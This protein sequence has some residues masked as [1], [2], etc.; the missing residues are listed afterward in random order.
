MIVRLAIVALCSAL[1]SAQSV[2]RDARELALTKS[3]DA[4]TTTFHLR[5]NY[6]A[7]ATAW[8]VEC[9]VETNHGQAVAS[10]WYWSDQEIGFEGKPL[11]PG[12]EIEFRIPSIPPNLMKAGPTPAKCENF[13]VVA[14]VF[15][16]GTVSGD[17]KWINAIVG[18]RQR[19]YQDITRATGLLTSAVSSN[20]DR[21]TLVKQLSDWAETESP[22]RARRPSPN[23]A[24]IFGGRNQDLPAGRKPDVDRFPPGRMGAVPCVTIWLL[25]EK[26]SGLTEAIG[27]LSEWRDRLGQLA[28]VT[29]PAQPAPAFALGNLRGRMPNDSEWVGKPAPDFTLKAVDGHELALKDLRGKTVFVD[30]WATWCVPCRE[31]MPQIAAL[32]DEFKASGLVVVCIDQDEPAET[33]KKYFEEHN[34]QFVNLV[35]TNKETFEKYGGD[36]IPKAVLIDKD[37]IIRYFQQGNDSRQDFPAEVRKLGLQSRGAQ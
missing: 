28:A 22:L 34:Y 14:A 6:S 23:Y 15:T 36:G 3:T 9:R 29:G 8:I 33:A 20:T 16:D 2:P 4:G 18:D 25:Q 37:G 30:F 35:D 32:Y 24:V 31:E 17:L 7:P 21:A 12:K 26:N 1:L 19:A 13:Q 11:T 5:N 10:Q 27:A